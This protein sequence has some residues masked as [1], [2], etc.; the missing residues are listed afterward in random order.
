MLTEGKACAAEPYVPRAVAT[1]VPV[2][3]RKI[4]TVESTLVLILLTRASDN[5]PQKAELKTMHLRQNSSC[6]QQNVIVFFPASSSMHSCTTLVMQVNRTDTEAYL[7]QKYPQAL[8]LIYLPKSF[9]TVIKSMIKRSLGCSHY[10][11][12]I[13][14]HVSR[15]CSNYISGF[16]GLGRDFPTERAVEDW[17]IN[18]IIEE[19]LAE[20]SQPLAPHRQKTYLKKANQAKAQWIQRRASR[21]EQELYLGNNDFD[22]E[23]KRS[24]GE[25]YMEL[26]KILGY[27][28]I[29]WYYVN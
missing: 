16:D 11:D 28:P 22:S 21:Q 19:Y 27:T 5:L 17:S 1:S 10:H 23:L 8:S 3:T 26:R 6:Q 13:L 4:F 14:D 15:Y 29:R 24:C 9:S 12:I 18:I 20:T 25:Y 7:W 2:G